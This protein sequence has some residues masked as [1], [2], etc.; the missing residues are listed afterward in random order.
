MS[1]SSVCIRLGRR[2]ILV[3]KKGLEPPHPC[4]YMDL[5][6]ARLPIPPL[7]QVDY[8]ARQLKELPVRKNNPPFYRRFLTCQTRLATTKLRTA[9]LKGRRVAD[10]NDR[11]GVVVH[12][13]VRAKHVQSWKSHPVSRRN[14]EEAM[15]NTQKLPPEI[16]SRLRSLAHDL[17]NSIETIMQASYLLGQIHQGSDSAKWISLIEDAAQ[18]AAHINREIREVLRTHS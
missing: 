9:H 6:H 10:P 4:G 1:H 7:R 15:A 14:R 2:E 18:D 13:G 3:P 12:R 5:N 17:S 16:V 8:V 11:C